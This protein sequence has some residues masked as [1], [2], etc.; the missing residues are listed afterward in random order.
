MTVKY[1][2]SDPTNGNAAYN[3]TDVGQRHAVREPDE[4]LVRSTK[5]GNLR[6]YLAYQNMVGQSTSR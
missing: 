4:L 1:F 6:F 3:L 2:L 5:F